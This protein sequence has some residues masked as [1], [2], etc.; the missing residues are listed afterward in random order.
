MKRKQS[1]PRP[2]TVR[3]N[4]TYRTATPYW[5][6][7]YGRKAAVFGWEQNAKDARERINRI[8]ARREKELGRNA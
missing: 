8:L 2:A 6:Y 7:L 1:K 5:L 3:F 4:G